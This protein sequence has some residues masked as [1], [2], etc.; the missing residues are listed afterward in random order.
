VAYRR[1]HFELAGD[2]LPVL[3][4]DPPG[5][6][7]KAAD[8][9]EELLDV[10]ASALEVS[11]DPRDVA[12]VRGT[13]A[14]QVALGMLE[15]AQS[16]R[17]YGCERAWWSIVTLESSP[18][19]FVLPVVFKGCA[20]GALEEGT[21]YHIAVAPLHRSRGLGRLL[22][23]RATDILLGHGVWRICCDTATENAPMIRLFEQHG[24]TRQSPSE[25]AAPI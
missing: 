17:V 13:G 7:W 20:R 16:G 11:S 14:R 23:G 2:A 24:W 12:A 10:F 9:D 1:V 8:D 4:H 22:L 25:V 5:V 3:Y 21:I 19:G 6:S 18:A 15:D